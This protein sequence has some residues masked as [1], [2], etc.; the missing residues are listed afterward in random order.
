MGRY[1][2]DEEEEV[3][4][5]PAKQAEKRRYDDDDDEEEVRPSKK[6]RDEE[7]DDEEDV[8][9]KSTVKRGWGAV[10]K[11]MTADSPFAQY[12]KVT[13]DRVIV[14]FLENE[15]YAV[16]RQHWINERVGRKSFTCIADAS[17]K[18]CPLCDAGSRPSSR[19][20]FNVIL[21]DSNGDHAIKSY[22]VGAR[23]IDQL[24]NFDSDPKQGPLSKHYWAISKSGRGPRTATNHQ[25]IR[26]RDL[27]EDY[28]IEPLT[29]A[30]LKRF[31][32]NAYDGSIVQIPTYKELL[33]IAEE[34]DD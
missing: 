16:Y 28:D 14:K 34:F 9:L 22:D 26:D 20:A 13:E 4:R 30:D 10:E 3:V 12:L 19:F 1:D 7:D 21:L 8:P 18:G 5:R 23:V 33:E 2:D 27:I 6:Y 11:V 29:D 15:P 17:P 25:M 24:K 32:R 31:T